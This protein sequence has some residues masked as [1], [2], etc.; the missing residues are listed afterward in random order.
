MVYGKFSLS[1]LVAA[2]C[3]HFFFRFRFRFRF[4]M[5]YN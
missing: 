4:R 3:I 1:K 2:A 5:W